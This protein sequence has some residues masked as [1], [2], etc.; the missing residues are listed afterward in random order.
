MTNV[1]SI[2]YSRD[3]TCAD[4]GPYSQRYGF[5]VSCIDEM[6]GPQRR[7]S[8]KESMFSNCGVGEDS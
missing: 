4:K 1:D 5:P 3:I 7:L 6:V 2:L 8:A